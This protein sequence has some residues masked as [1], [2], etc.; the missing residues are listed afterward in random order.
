[1]EKTKNLLVASDWKHFR[2]QSGYKKLV[3]ENFKL[4]RGIYFHTQVLETVMKACEHYA[5]TYNFSH[6]MMFLVE[7]NADIE[8]M[9]C[10]Y[11]ATYN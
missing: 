5:S 2:G 7:R 10:S 1:M 3:K 11:G 8:S 6:R 4:Y 9:K